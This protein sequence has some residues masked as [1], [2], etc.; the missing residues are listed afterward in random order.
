M[1]RS[2]DL[3]DSAF[4]CTY[5]SE[6]LYQKVYPFTDN[7]PYLLTSERNNH[8]KIIEYHE[9]RFDDY[10]SDTCCNTDEPEKHY[11]R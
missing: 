5:M 11:V 7:K 1:A 9:H 8:H 10:N 2:D 3:I 4:S 6:H